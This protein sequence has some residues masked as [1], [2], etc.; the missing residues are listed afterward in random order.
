MN[1]DI[2]N[3]CKNYCKDLLQSNEFK[4]EIYELTQPLIKILLKDLYP[5]I[6]ISIILVLICFFLLL[7]IFLIIILYI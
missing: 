2:Y 6:Y 1:T 7:G 4:K 3:E 5:Y